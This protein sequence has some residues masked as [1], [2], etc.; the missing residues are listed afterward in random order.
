MKSFHVHY[1]K[2]KRLKQMITPVSRRTGK[3]LTGNTEKEKPFNIF[4]SYI[5]ITIIIMR[6]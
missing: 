5:D 2:W 1:Q 6:Y 3:F 4:A